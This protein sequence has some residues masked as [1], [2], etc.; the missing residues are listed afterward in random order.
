MNT[1]IITAQAGVP[2][3]LLS[4]PGTGKT[5][6]VY[7]MAEALGRH[8]EVL[9]GSI[10]DPTDVGGMPMRVNGHC[11]FAPPGW[12]KRLKED[13]AGGILM[14]DELTGCP[15]SVQSAMLRLVAERRT[16]C[17]ELPSGTMIIAAANPPDQAANGHDL[18]P[19]MAN[20]FA[21]FD[22]APSVSDWVFG[23][24]SGWPKANVPTLPEHWE[25]TQLPKA[26]AMVASFIRSAPTH[27]QSMPG[28][29]AERSG[30]WPSRRTWDLAARSLAAHT[31]IRVAPEDS[32]AAIVGPA[33][34]TAFF[35]WLQAQDLP[36]PEAILSNPDAF[37][38]PDREDKAFTVLNSVV[39]AVVANNNPDR[40]DRA[41][42]VLAA[43]IKSNA[44]DIAVVPAR[45]LAAKPPPNLKSMPKA[46]TA[47]MPVLQQAGIIG[48]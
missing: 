35:S 26:R 38:L 18:A 22:W 33:A 42:R 43:T 39:G 20:R 28:T 36:D 40:Y 31:A 12:F 34:A 46:C 5:S 32:I 11:E 13:P 41:W 17:G 44:A 30:P 21:H 47:F 3:L 23:T 4:E 16:H 7:G 29:E 15:P 6:W 1:I 48:G 8:C 19:P 45:T 2:V 37:V 24:L 14:L 27:L 9:I 10:I 25:A